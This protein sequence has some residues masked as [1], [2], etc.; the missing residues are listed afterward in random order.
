MPTEHE[1]L[2]IIW[3]AEV[4]V[5]ADVEAVIVEVEVVENLISL[6][7]SSQ[8]FWLASSGPSKLA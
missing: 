8:P 6:T 5:V 1:H 4:E 3:I 2:E 7:R